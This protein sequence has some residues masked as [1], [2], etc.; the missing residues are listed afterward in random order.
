MAIRKNVP[1]TETT[2]DFGLV[3][4]GNIPAAANGFLSR[5]FV[6][7]FV[8]TVVTLIPYLQSAWFDFVNFDDPIYVS[9]NDLIRHG[10]NWTAT[11]DAVLRF[12]S[13]NWHPLVW[14]SY[15][16][17]VEVFGMSSGAMHISN[18]LL[19]IVNS[20]LVY[21]WLRVSRQDSV[22]SSCAALLF[23]IHPAHVES[24]AWV[25]ERKDVL[26][27][28]FL[29]LS[30]IGYTKYSQQA[31]KRW[32]LFSLSSFAIGLTAKGMLVTLP[33]MLILLDFWPLR[34]FRF[35]R[36]F[37]SET[38]LSR[39]IGEK[40]PY[41]IL[42]AV[43]CVVTVAAQKSGGAVSGLA[44]LS[45]TDR[46][47]N[48]AVAYL[49][50]CGMSAW[51]FRL[52]VFYPLPQGGWDGRIVLLA[53]LFL[54]ATTV[55]SVMRRNDRPVLL[56][57]WLWFLVTLLPVIGI[58]QVGI[59]SMADRYMYIPM[60]GLTLML[61]WSLPDRWLVYTPSRISTVIGSGVFL[62]IICAIQ[63]SVW[64]N[65]IT[66]FESSLIAVPDD[67]TVAYQNLSLAY[68]Q[69]GR[70]DDA[71]KIVQPRI[72]KYDRD[73]FL[74]LNMGNALRGL[75]RDVD[76]VECFR[77]AVHYAPKSS[78]ALN[79]LGLMLCRSDDATQ[80]TEGITYIRRAIE[81][82]PENAHAHNSLGNALVREG[83]LEAAQQSYL[84]AIRLADLPESKKNLD[85]VRELLGQL[86]T[87]P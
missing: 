83:S 16:V 47:S 8:L 20:I 44:A 2:P 5:D 37:A 60:V 42:S 7:I 51:P 13:A 84:E 66:L 50:Y 4:Y 85:Y 45:L 26:S 46:F 61:L 81:A 38:L 87:P 80:I 69:A 40:I 71:L 52:S 57:G 27:T 18:V 32:Y 39:L 30:L 12:H 78:E 9:D 48:A 74:W 33:V 1:A 54:V 41:V 15:M 73:P 55:F 28:L 17:E 86:G 31:S 6:A 76:A 3:Q 68:N 23:A 22:R 53:I 43:M 10:L 58:V 19:H 79:N 77:R 21:T 67:N 49:R 62:L 63:V 56:V 35:N 70:Y 59:Q 11:R 25:T 34:R 82:D 65:S 72:Q 14:L 29:F 75:G 36:R 24:V 64:K